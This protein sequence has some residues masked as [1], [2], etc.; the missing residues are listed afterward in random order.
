MLS[1]TSPQREHAALL[2]I[3]AQRDFV[4]AGS[5]LKLRG[6]R[7]AVPALRRLVEGFR[8]A[9][10]PIF[11]AIRLYRPNGSNVDNF[12]RQSVEEGLRVLMPGTS[13]AELIDA[14]RR[15]PSTRLDPPRLLRGALQEV[16]EE[17]RL[18]Y[19]PRWGAF[20]DTPLEA[21]LRQ[22][23][24][25]SLVICGCNFPTSVRSTIYEA[26]SRDFRMVLV[27]DAVTGATEESVRELGR[28]G[29]YLMDSKACL[30]W[31]RSRAAGHEAA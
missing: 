19:K 5:P 13:G 26:G 21:E 16:G 30:D 15:G 24:I 1:Y 20:H 27:T 9:Q 10:A 3:N 17:E 28:I 14:V 7:H 22:R 25:T 4:A 2:T 31:I 23:N 12:R 18:F 11:H 29:V 6:V 8:T